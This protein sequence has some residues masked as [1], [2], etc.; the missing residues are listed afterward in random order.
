ML[1]ANI[2]VRHD[3]DKNMLSTLCFLNIRSKID[4]TKCD[5]FLQSVDALCVCETWLTLSQQTPNVIDDSTVIR[6]DRTCGSRGGGLMIVCKNNVL[7]YPID[8]ELS[9]NGIE[10]INGTVV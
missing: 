3:H 1:T 10:S 9:N 8:I 2:D 4:D 7:Y 6:R 5:E